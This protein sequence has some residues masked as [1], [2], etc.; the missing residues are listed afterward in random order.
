MTDK[1]KKRQAP[2]LPKLSIE[3]QK[4]LGLDTGPVLVISTAPVAKRSASPSP[5]LEP[6][7]MTQMTP[8]EM[9]A[10][11]AAAKAAN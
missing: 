3:E 2:V 8:E 6:L 10:A 9:A 7:E 11:R 5:S 1:P 4:A